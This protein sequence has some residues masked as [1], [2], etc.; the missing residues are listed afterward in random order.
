MRQ[1]SPI[2]LSS[3]SNNADLIC[4]GTRSILILSLALDGP[5][6]NALTA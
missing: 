3:T 5:G 4:F 6:S 1:I 2:G